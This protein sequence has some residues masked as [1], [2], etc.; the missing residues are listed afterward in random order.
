MSSDL[1]TCPRCGRIHPRGYKCTVG[2]T[3]PKTYT[4]DET[5]LRN[6]SV[7][8]NKSKQIRADA[9]YLCEVCKDKGIYNYRDLS[10]HHIEKIRDRKDLW[11]EDDNLICLCRDHHRLA[12]AGT[13]SKIENCPEHCFI[14][15]DA[16][17]GV[18]CP[19]L[20]DKQWYVDIAKERLKGFGVMIYVVLDYSCIH[21]GK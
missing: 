4:Y 15:N 11:L 18:T 20:L 10:V 19:P 8:V 14:F 17:N 12:E 1:V 13:I 2:R 16:V 7:W 3:K 21:V 9:G 6:K 5:K